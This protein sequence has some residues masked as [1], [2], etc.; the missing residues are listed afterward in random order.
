MSLLLLFPNSG[1]STFTVTNWPD[2]RTA[3]YP[4]QLRTHVWPPNLN[5]LGKD[6]FFSAP[7]QGPD[8][9]WPNPK[10]PV[11]ATSLRTHLVSLNNTTLA[12]AGAVQAPFDQT[13]W[14]N[15]RQPLRTPQ[16]LD[17][18]SL[19]VSTLAVPVGEASPD[20]K[21]VTPSRVA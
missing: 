9:D 8:Y 18:R 3:P 11:Y 14:P 6:K 13:D 5:L 19:N 21:F 15:P 12:P 7:G 17:G 16:R 4:N 2:A 1:A 20:I 10:A